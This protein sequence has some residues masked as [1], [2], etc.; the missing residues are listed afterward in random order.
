[1]T[2]EVLETAP[3]PL[4]AATSKPR[5]AVDIF[6]QRL[7][8]ARLILIVL[9]VY[10]H[11]PLSVPAE[12]SLNALTPLDPAFIANATFLRFSVTILTIMSGF[13]MFTKHAD[14]RGMKTV[15]K[16]V[17]TL[18][19]PFLFWNLGLVAALYLAQRL[20]ILS[21]QRLDLLTA[22][23]QTWADATLA[24]STRP[25]NYPLYFLRDLF[26]ISLIAIVASRVVRANVIPV[27][28]V[29]VLIA[30]YNLDGNLILRTP[31][32]IAFFI[33]AALAIYKVPLD[34][35]DRSWPYFIPLLLVACVTHYYYPSESSGLLIS[36]LGGLTIWT[37][38]ALVH[39]SRALQKLARLA[40][41]AFP[42]YLIHGIILFG[43]LALGVE[44]SNSFT[45]LALWLVLPLVIAIVSALAFRLFSLILPQFASFTTGGRGA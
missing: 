28:A 12:R 34:A 2:A 6:S 24:W 40:K 31:M 14:Q 15:E 10:V 42:I 22:N 30:E 45:G 4:A 44:V 5:D 36:I 37:L 8:L 41:Y 33:G 13:I 18:L 20:G 27:I 21:G 19:V 38:T 39:R 11:F 43:V 23:A 32:L 35:L 25:V 29:S 1:M 16:K 7:S 3:A 26:V 9:V 17:R